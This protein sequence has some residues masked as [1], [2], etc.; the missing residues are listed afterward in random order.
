MN[1]VAKIISHRF[2]FK[3]YTFGTW[4]SLNAA[5]VKTYFGGMGAAVAAQQWK[6][7]ALLTVAMVVK[8]LA[9]AVDYFITEQQAPAK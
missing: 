5:Y 7:A 9:D 4:L 2:S 3:G 1:D 8:F 6:L